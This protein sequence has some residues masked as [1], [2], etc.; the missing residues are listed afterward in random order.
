MNKQLIEKTY[1]I[2]KIEDHNTDNQQKTFFFNIE[3]D[4]IKNNINVIKIIINSN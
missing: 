1:P 3:D 2:I 4:V